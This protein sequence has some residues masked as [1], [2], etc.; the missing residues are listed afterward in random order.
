MNS[1]AEMGDICKRYGS[2]QKRTI[3]TKQKGTDNKNTT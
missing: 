3:Q 1:V 2:L